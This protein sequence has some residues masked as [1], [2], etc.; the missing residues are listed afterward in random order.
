MGLQLKRNLTSVEALQ[1]G[2]YFV[3]HAKHTKKSCVSVAIC[4]T[5]CGGISYLTDDH[6]IDRSGLVTPI[7]SCRAAPCAVLDWIDLG[8]EFGEKP[9]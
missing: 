2:E 3:D 5:S 6:K 1:P 9:T 8:P 7:W 4:C